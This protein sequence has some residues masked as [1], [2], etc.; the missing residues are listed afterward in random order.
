MIEVFE[1]SE[2]DGDEP[3]FCGLSRILQKERIEKV[4]R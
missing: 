3:S 4:L 2:L 1:K